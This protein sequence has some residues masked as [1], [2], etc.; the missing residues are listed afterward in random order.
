MIYDINK[1]RG[2]ISELVH[3]LTEVVYK[4]TEIISGTHESISEIVHVL[5]KEAHKTQTLYRC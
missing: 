1:R 2:S 5:T 4:T 3:V